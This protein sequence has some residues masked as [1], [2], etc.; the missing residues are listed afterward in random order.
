[1]TDTWGVDILA[2]PEKGVFVMGQHKR[3]SQ[4]FKLQAAKLVVETGYTF[5]QAADRLGVDAST[6]RYWVRKFRGNGQLP[7][8]GTPVPQ[9]EA[10]RQ[11][12]QEVQQLR[13]ENEILKKAA[14]YFAKESL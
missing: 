5:A 7:P 1:M 11:L 10:F 12:Q 8:A 4:Q 14:A 9:A 2:A 13:L 6:I 3:Y